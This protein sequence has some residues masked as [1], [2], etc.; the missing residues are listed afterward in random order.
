MSACRSNRKTMG[1]VGKLTPYQHG[2]GSGSG[3]SVIN[4]REVEAAKS[5][6]MASL[7]AKNTHSPSL[8]ENGGLPTPAINDE[9]VLSP[10]D[11]YPS[12]MRQKSIRLQEK[13]DKKENSEWIKASRDIHGFKNIKTENTEKSNK[14]RKNPKTI[15]NKKT[16]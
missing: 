14:N 8:S 12:I 9:N 13:S 2:S 16:K 3:D 4:S 5:H 6:G 15:K 11:F 7:R 10:D 1:D